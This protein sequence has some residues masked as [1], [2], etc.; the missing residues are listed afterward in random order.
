MRGVVCTPS[1]MWRMS[2]GHAR[3][4]VSSLSL[5]CARRFCWSALCHVSVSCA[6]AQVSSFPLAAMFGMCA[7]FLLVCALCQRRLEHLVHA[8]RA[9]G[10]LADSN[11]VL[12]IKAGG[13]VLPNPKLDFAHGKG[14]LL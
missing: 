9:E 5:S 11:T 3:A 13:S 8:E 6:C 7:L 12:L 4:Q 2:Q 14:E 1:Q 10:G